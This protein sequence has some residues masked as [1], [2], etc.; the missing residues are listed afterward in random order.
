MKRSSIWIIIGL[1]TVALAGIISLQANWIVSSI[2]LNEERFDKNVFAAIYHFAERLESRESITALESMN[3]YESE[4]L[5]QE[6]R[7]A[8][9][10]GGSELLHLP[11]A[12]PIQEDLPNDRLAAFLLSQ[13]SCDCDACRLERKIKYYQIIRKRLQRNQL[14]LYDRIGDLSFFHNLLKEE[15]ENAGIHTRFHYGIFSNETSSFIMTDG[16]Y[17]V[18]A[19]NEQVSQIGGF[20]QLLNSEY[21]VSLFPEGKEAPGF[22]MIRFPDRVRTVWGSVIRNLVGSVLFTGIILFCFAYT[23][24]VIFRQ[25]KI[26]EM[27]ND[28]INNMTHEFKTPIATISLATDAIGNPQVAGNAGKV[29]RF[30]EIIRQENRRMNDQ[31]EKVLQMALIDKQDIMLKWSPVDIHEIIRSAVANFALQIEQ[32]EGYLQL[33]L[34]ADPPVVEGDPTH[35]ASMIH[36]LLDNAN[37]YSPDKPE[38]AIRTRNVP[39]GVEVAIRDKGL[40]ISREARRHIFDKFYRVHTGNLHD[41][42]G[43]G[44]GLSYVKAMMDAHHGEVR[45][46]SETGKGSTFFLF[47]PF[48]QETV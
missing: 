3:G 41:V 33:D 43:F 35:I 7:A 14:G 44:L 45:V 19:L 27:R 32:R 16:H 5:E 36:N 12:P 37:K 38:I 9:N 47:F 26:S 1:M 46:E 48:K 13:N 6:L 4:F 2:R 24:M 11:D 20:D 25:K 40:G 39:R 17:V 10:R 15:L 30:A 34:Q 8:L 23:I 21:R 18:P 42:K 28:F 31:V 29:K 22:L